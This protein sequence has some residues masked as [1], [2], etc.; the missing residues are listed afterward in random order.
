MMSHNGKVALELKQN[1]EYFS[2]CKQTAK[3]AVSWKCID[4]LYIELRE[5]TRF[6]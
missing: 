3:C 1:I 2:N 6:R 4:S 5:A